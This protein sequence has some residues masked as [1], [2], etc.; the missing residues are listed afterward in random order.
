MDNA[1]NVRVTNWSGHKLPTGFPE[2]RR[3]WLH[4][5]FLDYG[6][7]LLEERGHYDYDEAY[8]HE[9]GT[10]VYEMKLGMDEDIA[11][12]TNME[13]G[14]SFHLVLNNVIMK[15]NR[16]PPVGFTNAEFEAIKAAPVGET[17]QDGQHWHDTLYQIPVG[18]SE[19]VVTLWFQTTSREYMEFLRDKNV[20]DDRGQI[21]WDAYVAR[22]KSAP[23]AMDS[24]IY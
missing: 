20:T 14:E 24:I 1:L 18:A 8:L 23:V 3:M 17:F 13:P 16:I 2:G 11:A 4:V 7:N 15:D 6:G 21:A 10:T 22:G 5:R 19:A 9:E 12:A